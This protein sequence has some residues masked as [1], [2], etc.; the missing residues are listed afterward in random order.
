MGGHRHH[1]VY[2][3]CQVQAVQAEKRQEAG[4]SSQ[5]PAPDPGGHPSWGSL[6]RGLYFA[7]RPENIPFRR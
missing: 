6:K 2:F 5:K 7:Q 1:T 4:L 3:C